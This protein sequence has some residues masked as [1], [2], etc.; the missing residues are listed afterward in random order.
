MCVCIYLFIY[1]V[2]SRRRHVSPSIFFYS[3][4]CWFGEWFKGC[5]RQEFTQFSL[6]LYLFFYCCSTTV[7]PIFPPSLSPTPLTPTFHTQSNYPHCLCPWVLYTCSLMTLFLL[8]P[9]ILLPFPFWLLSV[10]SFLQFLWIYL[11]ACLFCW[12]G[13]TY[14]WDNMVFVFHLL[15]YCT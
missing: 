14:R 5:D 4:V 8:S 13:S 1:L 12:L 3:Y 2:G 10:F 11:F 9:I 15:A 7:V 6:F